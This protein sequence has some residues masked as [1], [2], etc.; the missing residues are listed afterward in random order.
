MKSST[1]QKHHQADFK[2]SP[3]TTSSHNETILFSFIYQSCSTVADKDK[4]VTTARATSNS[5]NVLKIEIFLRLKEE[6]Y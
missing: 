5:S 4:Q 3:E 1:T 6:N 2:I